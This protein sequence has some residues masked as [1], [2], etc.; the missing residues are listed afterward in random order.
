VS[1]IGPVFL[2]AANAQDEASLR[3]H[4][5]HSVRRVFLPIGAFSGYETNGYRTV[6]LDAAYEVTRWARAFARVYNVGDYYQSDIDNLGVTQGR[7]LL[8]GVRM[9]F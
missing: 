6:D 4:D 2:S 7:R 3:A 1:Y 9:Q 5:P 8:T